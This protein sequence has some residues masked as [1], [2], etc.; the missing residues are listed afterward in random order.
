MVPKNF[1][2]ILKKT[3]CDENCKK[4]IEDKTLC[5]QDNEQCFNVVYPLCLRQCFLAF[6][7]EI[8]EQ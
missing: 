3:D 8:K 2:R 1:G 6:K 5:S 4:Q 7:F